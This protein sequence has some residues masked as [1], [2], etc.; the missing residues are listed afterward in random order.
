MEIT[1]KMHTGNSSMMTLPRITGLVA[2]L[3]EEALPQV[4]VISNSRIKSS[5]DANSNNNKT[6]LR[7]Q[8]RPVCVSHLSPFQVVQFIQ[9]NGETG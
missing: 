3:L 8:P 1:L 2:K 6:T 7:T 4:K 5:P 9:V